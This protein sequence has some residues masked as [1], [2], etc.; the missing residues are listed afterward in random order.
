MDFQAVILNGDGYLLAVKDMYK[1]REVRDLDDAREMEVANGGHAGKHVIQIEGEDG[2][3]QRVY[4][5]LRL[6]RCGR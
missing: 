4:V 1:N 3:L 2:T 5:V 6:S